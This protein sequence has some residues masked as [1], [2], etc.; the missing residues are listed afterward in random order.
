MASTNTNI[1]FVIF[2]ATSK[3]DNPLANMNYSFLTTFNYNN[4]LIGSY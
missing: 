4:F 2:L 3:K 1:N